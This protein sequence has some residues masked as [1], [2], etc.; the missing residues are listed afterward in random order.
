MQ[1]HEVPLD[2]IIVDERARKDYGDIEELA[3]SIRDVGLLQPI[4]VSDEYRLLAGGRRLEAARLAGLATIPA[5]MR[6]VDGEVNALEIELIE[7]SVR[8]DLT[9][10][11]QALLEKRIYDLKGSVRGAAAALDTSRTALFRNV[12]LAEALTKIPEIAECKTPADALK[13]LGKMQERVIVSELRR[14]ADVEMKALHE[15]SDT[16]RFYKM[17][18]NHYILGDAIAG[19]RA[20]GG[21]V[22]HFAEVDPPY[23]IDLDE[24]KRGPDISDVYT[25]VPEDEYA[26]FLLTVGK[27]VFRILEGNAFCI[28]WFG[29]QHYH[30][31]ST[32]LSEVGF[33]V[34]AVPCIWNKGNQGQTLSPN[35]NLASCHEPFFICRKGLPILAK[36]GRSNVFTFDPVAAQGKIHPTERPLDLMQEILEVFLYPN[37]RVIVPFLGSGNTLLAAYSRGC[38]GTGWDLEASTKDRFLLRVTNYAKALKG[39]RKEG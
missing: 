34:N 21:G 7:N 17:A 29:Y 26:S 14:R 12:Q 24:K 2:S 8:K 33:K 25:E 38:V 11:E 3:A 22:F 28:W 15:G 1:V 37:Q 5:V 23:G 30:T 13:L 6:R 18:D 9:W 16:S 39:E 31:V 20:V 10:Q 19:L 27:E 32:I 36:Q 4:T 35:T